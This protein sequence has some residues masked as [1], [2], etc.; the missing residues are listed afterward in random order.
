MNHYITLKEDMMLG[1]KLAICDKNTHE[2]VMNHYTSSQEY[3][4]K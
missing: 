2:D 4:M 3:I 1:R